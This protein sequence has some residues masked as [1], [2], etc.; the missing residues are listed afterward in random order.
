MVVNF[1]AIT[2]F[3]DYHSRNLRRAEVIEPHPGTILYHMA[4]S[5]YGWLNVGAG[6]EKIRRAWWNQ[7]SAFKVL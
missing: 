4:D 7:Q 2:E 5:S 1:V 3:S 6:H